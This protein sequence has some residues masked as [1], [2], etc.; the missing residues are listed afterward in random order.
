MI[1]SWKRET[2]LIP[3]LCQIHRWNYDKDIQTNVEELAAETYRYK[4]FDNSQHPCQF[5]RLQ[6]IKEY[7][8]KLKGLNL[9]RSDG[10]NVAFTMIGC[11][12]VGA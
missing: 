5:W 4:R 7:K 10:N 9:K 11:A 3:R 6:T 8:G 1:Y 12:K 2:F